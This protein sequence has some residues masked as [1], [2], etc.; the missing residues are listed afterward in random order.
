[1]NSKIEI[2][3]PIII[4]VEGKD[5]E[6]F[7]SSFINELFPNSISDCNI[8][9]LQGKTNFKS[10]ISALSK[11]PGFRENVKVLLIFLDA[12]DSLTNTFRSITNTL[13]E[14]NLPDPVKP[15]ELI[16]DKQIKVGVYIFPNSKDNGTLEDLLIEMIKETDNKSLECIYR[17]IDC[18]KKVQN[19]SKLKHESKSI[20]YSYFAIKQEPSDD[21]C[22]SIKR[23]ALE[24]NCK[25][26]EKL[27]KFFEEAIKK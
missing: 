7:L 15:G 21:P 19:I 25:S 10:Q 3:K 16:S 26:I 13:K 22:T 14:L 1:M 12:D 18:I 20:L 9:N 8:I 6:Q 11:T 4:L 23:K 17:Y 24:F 2:N 5:D 27:R